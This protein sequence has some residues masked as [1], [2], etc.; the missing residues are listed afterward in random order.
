MVQF[1]QK[2][3]ESEKVKYF[4]ISKIECPCCCT[5]KKLLTSDRYLNLD[6]D[7][8]VVIY[9]N[10]TKDLL[11]FVKDEK[12][13]LNPQLEEFIDVKNNT[14]AD[15]YPCVFLKDGDKFIYLK[16]GKDGMLKRFAVNLQT[17][18][19]KLYSELLNKIKEKLSDSEFNTDILC[20][21][22]E[23]ELKPDENELNEHITNLENIL[24]S[25]HNN[26]IGQ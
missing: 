14:I 10:P 16:G 19:N 6:H 12:G 24:N 8:V 26:N 20:K 1:L 23:C 22:I 3:L 9:D 2:L 7:K 15:T 4:I 21:Y 5:V 13:I 18:D 25:Q 17:K 11:S